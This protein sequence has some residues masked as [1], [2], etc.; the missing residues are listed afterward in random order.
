MGK[1]QRV[2]GYTF[3]RKIAQLFKSIG[4][5]DAKRHLEFQYQEAMGYDLDG[6]HPYYIQCKKHKAYVPINTIE[7]V[8]T[9][10]GG[11]P[12]LITEPDRKRALVAIYLDD[13]INLLKLVKGLE[14]E[15][16]SKTTESTSTIT[17]SD[18]N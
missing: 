13:F 2:K 4:F 6:T 1:A 15:P 17:D 5:K 9:P 7:E 11:I 3:E 16:S 14:H 10:V 12:V 8:K 18:G